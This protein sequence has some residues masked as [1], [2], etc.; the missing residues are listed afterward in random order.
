VQLPPPDAAV[1]T[2]RFASQVPPP[3]VAEHLDKHE[4]AFITQFTGESARWFC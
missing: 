1:C 4:K 2:L 3:Q